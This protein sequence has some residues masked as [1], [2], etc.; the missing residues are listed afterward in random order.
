LVN[1]V[2]K[3]TSKVFKEMD[4]TRVGYEIW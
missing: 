1:H 3:K 2:V 4:K